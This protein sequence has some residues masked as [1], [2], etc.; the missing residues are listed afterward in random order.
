MLNK[1]QHFGLHCGFHLQGECEEGVDIPIFTP[2]GILVH[3][4]FPPC[5][6]SEYDDSVCRNSET[7]LTDDV[8]RPRKPRL[9]T[10]GLLTA[11]ANPSVQ[12]Q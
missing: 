4:V 6:H 5:I 2:P 11:W 9:D 3:I 7:A 12:L 8:A 1:F 10:E